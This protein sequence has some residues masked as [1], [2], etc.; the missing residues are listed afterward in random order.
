MG[1]LLQCGGTLWGTKA[2][3]A[4]FRAQMG[5]L[6]VFGAPRVGTLRGSFSVVARWGVFLQRIMSGRGSHSNLS[7]DREEKGT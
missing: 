5:K 3:L 6:G 4:L 1:E 2:M 7:M